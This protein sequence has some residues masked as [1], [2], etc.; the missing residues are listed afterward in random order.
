[1]D[2]P[3]FSEFDQRAQA[4][5]SLTVAFLGGSLTW[6]AQ[7]S[8]PLKTSY[9]ALIQ[10]QLK[11]K[12]PEAHFTFVDAAIGGTGSQ[13]GAFRLERDLLAYKPDLAFLDFTVNDSAS[14][15]PQDDR[16]SSYESLA[17]RMVQ[18]NIPVVQVIL[19][20]KMDVGPNARPRPLVALH[21]AIGKAYGLP[22]ADAQAHMSAK[23]RSGEVTLDELWDLPYDSTHPGD[24]GYALY[25]EAVWDAYLQAVEEGVVCQAPDAMLHPDHYMDVDRFS[26][27][28]LDDLPSGWQRG[29][30]HRS[31]VAFDFVCSRWMDDLATAEATNEDAPAPLMLKFTG[32][33]VLLFGEGTPK[34]GRYSV[35]IDGGEAVEYNTRCSSGNM[36]HVQIVGIHL[37]PGVEHT[38]EITPLLE[39]G[40]E[41]RLNSVCVA[42]GNV[43]AKAGGRQAPH[44][45]NVPYG[46]HERNVMDVWL[47]DSVPPTPCVIF[48]HGGGWLNGDKTNGANPIPYL[49][50]GI[51]YVAINYR[52]LEQT[53]INTQS[54]RGAGAI[55]PRGDYA[56]PPVRVPL[57]DAARALQ[58]VRA[59]EAEWK[60]DPERIGLTGGSAGACTSL[61]LAFHG[62]LA[63]PD[64]D[65]PILRQ[66]TRV[67]C[68]AVEGAQT[69]L[70]PEQILEWIPNA[71]YGGHAFGY[72]WDQSDPTVEIRSFAADRSSVTEWIAEYSPYALLT[73]NDPPVFLRYK[74]AP[75]KGKDQDDATHSANY[76]ALLAEKL[77]AQGSDY[78]YVHAGSSSRQFSSEAEF[79]IHHLKE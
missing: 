60:I 31:A 15:V 64:A 23:V 16:L 6:G 36:R 26:L 39:P 73:E 46:P 9:R 69:T 34:S 29:V 68:V 28:S 14:E 54:E 24:A 5:E 41:L 13:L 30:P 61:W 67:Q 55:Q 47:A 62:D 20:V 18:V 45:E 3:S 4:G 17:R 75:E 38:I 7:A 52:F 12:Y 42:G 70:D 27:A 79:L 44:F 78:A 72:V 76:G 22:L 35:R 49:E 51:S 66:S 57:Y 43:L 33:T 37:E 48:I 40:E 63:K 77:D 53:V 8:D 50:A 58:F 71:T 25:A 11:T 32:Q 2:S 74:G 19:A 65:D 1:M 10:K 59:N 56:E 21:E